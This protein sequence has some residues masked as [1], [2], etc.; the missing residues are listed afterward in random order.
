MRIKFAIVFA[1]FAMASLSSMGQEWG[2]KHIEADELRGFE[3]KTIHYIDADNYMVVV[4]ES[5][6]SV[7]LKNGIFDYGGMENT[8]MV[9]VGLYDSIANLNEKL[10]FL[11][12]VN[13][14]QPEIIMLKD[15]RMRLFNSNH[16]DNFIASRI[17]DYLFSS[18]GT[19]RFIIPVYHSID[20]D[21][22]LPTIKN[23]NEKNL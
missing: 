4:S 22:T 3:E 21:F 19:V 17:I 15:Y 7:V 14:K 13:P 5:D 11:G 12:F 8:A 2:T 1:I 20:L 10:K 23:T 16:P 9:T 6:I 18:N